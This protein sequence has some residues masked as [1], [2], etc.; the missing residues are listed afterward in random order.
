MFV[1]PRA[2]W[3][4]SDSRLDLNHATCVLY[5][6]KYIDLVSLVS[7]AGRFPRHVYQ[8]SLTD[9]SFVPTMNAVRTST[10]THCM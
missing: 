9:N 4:A 1:T 8:V 2:E 3:K 10:E 7:F 5:G 6:V